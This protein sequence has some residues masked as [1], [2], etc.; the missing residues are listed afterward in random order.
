MTAYGETKR[1]MLVGATENFESQIELE[2]RAT[3]SLAGCPDGREDVGA[4]I[5]KRKPA[6]KN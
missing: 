2:G 4:F 1:L 5:D 6:F 3:S